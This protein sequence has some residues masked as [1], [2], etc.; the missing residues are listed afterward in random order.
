MTGL[1]GVGLGFRPELA[2]DL[3]R[4]PSGVDFVEVVAEACQLQSRA[5]REAH[6]L[7]EIWPVVPHGVKLSLGAAEGI[8]AGRARALGTLARELRAPAISEHV[9]FVRSGGREIGHLTALPLTRAALAVVEKNVARAR[10]H[11]PDVPL[12]LENVA[13]SFCWPDAEMSEGDFYGEVTER[14]GSELLLDV[15]NL[16]ANALNSAEDPLEAVERFP[17]ERVGMLH[18]AGGVS[19]EGF[20]FDDHA[21]AVPDG[22]FELIARVLARSGPVPILLER[23]ALFPP[24]AELSAELDRARALLPEAGP[25]ARSARAPRATDRS[26]ASAI[27]T[28]RDDQ[29]LVAKL[30]TDVKEPPA[31]AALRFGEEALRRSRTI[32]KRKRVDEALPLLPELGRRRPELEALAH[33][34]VECA[35]RQA[36]LAAFSDA[37]HIAERALG[38][39]ELTRAAQRDCLLLRSRFRLD[40]PSGGVRPRRMPFLAR[41]LGEDGARLWALKGLG[42]RAR[43]RIWET[44]RK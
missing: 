23:D 28:L 9:A 29:D 10:R 7:A 25:R 2:G 8:D 24:F 17:L 16:Y 15:G 31:S 38:R 34:T 35:V 6:A 14:T 44:R 27:A 5:R 32:L 37:W 12:Y 33:E 13:W 19:E 41:E 42:T 21:H 40:A 36:E 18:V 4:R 1:S 26:D 22:V 30:L 39:P 20:Y 3:L 43:V 11:L